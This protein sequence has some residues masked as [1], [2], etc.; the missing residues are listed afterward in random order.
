MSP[1]GT[2]GIVRGLCDLS[3]RLP[4]KNNNHLSVLFQQEFVIADQIL[5]DEFPMGLTPQPSL[6]DLSTSHR[7]P[8][9]KTLGYLQLSLRDRAPGCQQCERVVA[10]KW[11]RPGNGHKRFQEHPERVPRPERDG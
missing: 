5:H 8:K 9:V 11:R 6:R 4:T 1:E 3:T 7:T 2:A 10:A